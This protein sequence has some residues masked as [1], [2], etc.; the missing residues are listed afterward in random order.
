MQVNS[1]VFSVILEFWDLQDGPHWVIGTRRLLSSPA[2][3]LVARL[4]ST[5]RR[6]TRVSSSQSPRTWRPPSPPRCHSHPTASTLW[7]LPSGESK[8][9]IFSCTLNQPTENHPAMSYRT[10]GKAY[11]KKTLKFSF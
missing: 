8:K 7:F 1:T 9:L 5:C 11:H 10:P 6:S 2:C 3:Q 4:T